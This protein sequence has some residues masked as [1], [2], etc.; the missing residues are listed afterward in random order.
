MDGSKIAKSSESRTELLSRIQ[1]P[2][3]QPRGTALYTGVSRCLECDCDR[4]HKPNGDRLTVHTYYRACDQ[5][6]NG[7]VNPEAA[8][9]EQIEESDKMDVDLKF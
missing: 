9:L 1:I 4:I 8:K 5:N 6:D 2:K 7:V 3:R